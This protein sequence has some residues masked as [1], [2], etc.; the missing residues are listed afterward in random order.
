[1]SL[2]ALTAALALLAAAALAAVAILATVLVGLRR[3]EAATV[4][5][6]PHRRRGTA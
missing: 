6:E 4:V 2:L 1:M 5:A 3:L